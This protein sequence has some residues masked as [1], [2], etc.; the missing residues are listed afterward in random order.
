MSEECPPW[1]VS[2]NVHKGPEGYGIYFTQKDGMV[3]VTKLDKGSEAEKAGVQPGD[4]LNSVKD[5]EGKLPPDDPGGEVIVGQH[6]YQAA[7]SLVR[8]MKY[9]CLTFRSPGFS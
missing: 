2:V 8:T 3:K 7:L 5:L 6:N 4:E 1:D 9:C